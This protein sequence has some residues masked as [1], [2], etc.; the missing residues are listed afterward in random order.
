V[1]ENSNAEFFYSTGGT[2]V[3]PSWRAVQRHS[4]P[5]LARARPFD[6]LRAGSFDWIGAGSF[7]G[8]R[9]GCYCDCRQEIAGKM[10]ALQV[11]VEV[12]RT[13]F[14]LRDGER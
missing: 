10:P 6:W 11:S 3:R 14:S 8:L 5:L 1:K 4:R 13:G 7:G 2:G 12:V 9:A